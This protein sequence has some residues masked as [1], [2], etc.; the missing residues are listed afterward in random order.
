MTKIIK[1]NITT[2]SSLIVS[3]RSDRAFYTDLD[4][5]IGEYCNKN[6]DKYLDR[7]GLR[8]VYPFYRYGQYECYSPEQAEYYLPGSSI[9]GALKNPDGKSKEINSK[10]NIMAE[11]IKIGNDKIVLRNLYKLQYLDEPVKKGALK[12]FF[13]NVGIEMVR[14]G[15]RLEGELFSDMDTVKHLLQDANRVTKQKIKQMLEYLEMIK[16]TEARKKG[17]ANNVN[18]IQVEK[19]GC[20][21]VINTIIEKLKPL[22]N[23]D[24]IF[25]LGG[26]KG[27]LHSIC[28]NKAEEINSAVFIDQETDLPHGLISIDLVE[29]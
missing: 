16:E 6:Y 24:N 7:D 13:E 9:K 8:I 20:V 1:Y 19:K 25:L 28:L 12:P 11:D 21:D 10:Q 18:T 26:Y 3:P 4:D 14:D 29:V 15:V 5:S 23:K 22:Q 27:L 17:C 2:V